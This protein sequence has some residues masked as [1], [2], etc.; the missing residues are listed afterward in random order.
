MQKRFGGWGPLVAG[1]ATALISL[2]AAA[3]GDV[4]PH[5]VDTSALKQLGKDWLDADPYRGDKQAVAVGA[6]GYLHNCAGCHGLNAEAGGM[7]PDLLKLDQDCLGMNGA[8]KASCLQDTD[9]YFK[10]VVLNGK[11]NSEGRVT[12]PAY[13]KVFTQEAVWAVKAYIDQRTVEDSGT[14]SN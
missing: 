1:L 4:T 11:K 7:A 10:D 9:E 3:H 2:T 6:K 13:D 14:Q 12:M 8:S 5:P